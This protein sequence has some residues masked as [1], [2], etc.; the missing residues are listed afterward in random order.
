MQ[1][2]TFQ[3]SINQQIPDS[4]HKVVVVRGL[5]RHLEIKEM[6]AKKEYD[7]MKREEEVFGY[8]KNYNS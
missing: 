5:D 1:N 4:F 2:C 8:G 3:P 6:Q 7:Q